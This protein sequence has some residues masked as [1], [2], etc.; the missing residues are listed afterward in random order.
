MIEVAERLGAETD[1]V[2]VDLYVLP[3]RIV[4]GEL[5]SFPAAGDS[6]F[7]PPSFNARFGRHWTVPPR[8]EWSG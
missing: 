2:R 7:D 6:P 8:Y 4:V 1:F 3:N 5:T